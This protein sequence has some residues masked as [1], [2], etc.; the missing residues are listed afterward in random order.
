MYEISA[1]FTVKLLDEQINLLDSIKVYT[2]M[3]HMLHYL[4]G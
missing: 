4:S 2:F 1:V 3:L